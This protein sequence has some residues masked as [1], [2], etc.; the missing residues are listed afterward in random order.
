MAG[1]AAILAAG[2]TGLAFAA[3]QVQVF[4]ADRTPRIEAEARFI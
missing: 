3:R 2:A 4:I 1:G